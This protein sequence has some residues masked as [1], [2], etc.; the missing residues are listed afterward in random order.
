MIIITVHDKV[1]GTWSAPAVVQNKECAVRDFRSATS[2]PG[3]LLSEHPEDF[4]LWIIGDWNVPYDTKKY[5]VLSVFDN[6]E[7]VEVG[8]T[9]RG[10]D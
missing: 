9:S 4:E 8:V 3:S 7:F 5:P 1:A 2:K 6:F 10:Q